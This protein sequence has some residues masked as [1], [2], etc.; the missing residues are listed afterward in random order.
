MDKSIQQFLDIGTAYLNKVF[1]QYA[2]DP[3]KIAE[4]V[5]GVTDVMVALGCGIIAEQW[6]A[7]DRIL[8]D[9]PDLRPGWV[10]ERT[11][12]KRTVTTSLG[13][14]TFH[15]TYYHNKKTGR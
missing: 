6:E 9:W 13:D 2:E 11:G 8:H 5:F 10:V 7:Y 15:R 4:M 3:T 1:V 14:V 12:D